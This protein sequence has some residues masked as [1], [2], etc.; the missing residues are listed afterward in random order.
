WDEHIVW[1]KRVR[2]RLLRFASLIAIGY[3]LHLPYFSLRKTWN[4]ASP[5]ELKALLQSDVLQCIG[6]TLL[7]LQIAVLLLKKRKAFEWIIASGAAI[8]IF[9]APLMWSA[10]LAG[11]LPVALASYLTPENGSW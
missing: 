4:E 6:V 8:V 2:T 11:S 9:S 10:R 1:G 5:N 7:L 3:A